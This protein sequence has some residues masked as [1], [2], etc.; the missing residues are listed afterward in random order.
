MPSMP[1]PMLTSIRARSWTCGSHAALPMT[2]SPGVRA[3]A[4][5]AFSVAM[6]DGSSMKTSPA[7]RPIGRD[8]LDVA[9]VL[10]GRPERLER[11]EVRIQAPAADDVAAGR[12][13]P[14]APEPREQ[15]S[16]EQERGADALGEPAVEHG[17]RGQIGRAER[18]LVVGEPV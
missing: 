8:D 3:A 2:V 9:L 14:D 16:R 5:S 15:G 12:W 7:R 11:V 1:A 10:H 13:H 6:T 4:S 18:D 17:V